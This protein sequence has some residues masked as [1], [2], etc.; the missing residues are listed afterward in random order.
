[1]RGYII[2]EKE[3]AIYN[4]SY[5]D[6]YIRTGKELGLEITLVLYEDCTYGINHARHFITIHGEPIEKI[7]FAIYRCRDYKLSRQ[8]EMMGIR[9]FNNANVC[10]IANDK[11]LTYQYV[12]KLGLPCI[13]ST[14]VENRQLRD[15][16]S[17]CKEE[18]VVK[19]V[20][21]HGGK[22]VCLVREPSAIE[23]VIRCM[24][25]E[26]VVIQPYVK[27]RGEDLRVYV[28]GT[29]IIASVLRHA[30]DDFRANFSLGGSVQLYTLSQEEEQLVKRIIALFDF[31]YVGIDF[32]IGEHGELIFNEIEDV[33][34]ARM[35][36]HCSNTPIVR[37]Y[38]E[39]IRNSL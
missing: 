39:H 38:L 1:M 14:F 13:D 37:L 10:R 5:I 25:G 16:L 26:D 35:L 19:A 6:E 24:T 7:E 21:G 30:Q 27:G 17:S 15:Y 31:D 4:K 2:Y 23:D 9:V 18:V 22:Q 3:A 8:F 28:I 20:H 34:G 33:V 11:A 32:I 36:Y 12:A 29:T